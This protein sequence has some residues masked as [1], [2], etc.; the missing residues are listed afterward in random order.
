MKIHRNLADGQWGQLQSDTDRWQFVWEYMRG[1]YAPQSAFSPYG[2]SY[3]NTFSS[4]LVKDAT[5]LAT[6][7]KVT[8]RPLRQWRYMADK[9]GQGEKQG[10][11]KPE[12]DDKGWKVTDPCVATW[13]SLGLFDY[14]S[15]VWYRAKVVVPA[16]PAGKKVFLW[17]GGTDGNTKLFVNGQHVP[18]INAKGEAVPEHGGYCDPVSFD[19]TKVV[20]PGAENHF[21]L[22]CTRWASYI[23]ELGTGGLMGPLVVYHE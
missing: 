22:F 8:T 9:D 12:F 6:T 21:A 16:V 5:R 11:N 23:N 19:I 2:A 13:S 3:F 18:F 17:I 15:S 1:E 4:P 10:W 14:F 20:K 7:C